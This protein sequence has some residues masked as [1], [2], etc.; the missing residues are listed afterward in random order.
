MKPEHRIVLARVLL[1]YLAYLR[2]LCP[3]KMGQSLV[4][5]TLLLC[6]LSH[7]T[8]MAIGWDDRDFFSYC[9]PS[10]CS[11]DGPEIRF[12]LRLPSDSRAPS[13]CGST[14]CINLACSG[15]DTILRHPFL[16]PSKVTAIDY[17]LGLVRIIPLADR[18]S[19]CPVSNLSLPVHVDNNCGLYAND[20]GRLVGCSREF[21]PHDLTP[22]PILCENCYDWDRTVV[23]AADLIAGPIHCLSN[24]GRFIYLVHPYLSMSLLQLDCKAVSNSAIPIFFTSR[25][26]VFTYKDTSTFKQ[27]A[28]ATISF[29]EITVSWMTRFGDG[30]SP[31][32]N[33]SACERRGRRCAFSSQRNLTFCM[34]SPNGI[35]SD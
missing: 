25:P 8:D 4:S 28:E 13:S 34:P 21:T 6:L 32:Y 16:G 17:K 3:S 23:P 22:H 10:Q 29:S 19:E 30:Y 20:P 27:R 12:P 24:S 15:Q 18:S 1:Q 35:I 11:K 2:L 31:Y 7:G 33:C 9:P 5:T 14:T 26:A